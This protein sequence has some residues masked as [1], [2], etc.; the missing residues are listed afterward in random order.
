MPHCPLLFSSLIESR[1]KLCSWNALKFI[2]YNQGRSAG[3]AHWQNV[4]KT[5]EAGD[6]LKS[7]TAQHYVKAISVAIKNGGG[8]RDP[9]LNSQL[10]SVLAEAKANS[11]PSST[12]ER[13]LKA[14]PAGIPYLLEI[15]APGGLFVLVKGLTKSVPSERHKLTAIVKRFGCTVSPSPGRITNEFFNH[16]GLVNVPAKNNDNL[17]DLD[18]ATNLGIELGAEEVKEVTFNSSVVFQFHCHPRAMDTLR[19]ELEQEHN[20]V[21]SSVEDVY[22][23]KTF[24]EVSPTAYQNLREMYE[25]IRSQHE[26]L[27]GI[28]DNVTIRQE[29]K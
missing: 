28:F 12:L 6:K 3:H 17:P 5:K 26:N 14:E 1:I 18:S 23:P 9:R 29:N 11:V 10:A 2:I 21:V 22:I 20:V 13:A 27:E 8:I 24:V 19:Q 15:I 16:V 4:K 7:R 25:K